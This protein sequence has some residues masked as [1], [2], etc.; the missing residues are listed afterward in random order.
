MA[1]RSALGRRRAGPRSIVQTP[2]DEANGTYH[3]EPAAHWLDETF[4]ITLKNLRVSPVDASI[5][6]Q[7]FRHSRWKIVTRSDDYVKKDVK[8]VEFPVTATASGE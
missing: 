7:L 4:A 3:P 6:E 2:E 5:I 1:A 8:R